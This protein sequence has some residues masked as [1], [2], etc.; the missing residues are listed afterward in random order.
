M[1]D[2]LSQEPR[3]VST[4]LLSQPTRLTVLAL[5]TLGAFDV[6]RLI[7]G[8]IIGP[9]LADALLG[10]PGPVMVGNYDLG[11]VGVEVLA[12]SVGV[13]L[14]A[15]IAVPLARVIVRR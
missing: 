14:A 6:G 11:R 15:L 7:A 12:I 5:V 1:S 10:R 8:T 3:T 2:T 9:W 4:T 13:G